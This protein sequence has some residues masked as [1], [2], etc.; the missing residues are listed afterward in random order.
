[1]PRLPLRWLVTSEKVSKS[2]QV[3]VIGTNVWASTPIWLAVRSTPEPM[4]AFD[5]WV[6]RSTL[7]AIDT[8]DEVC[9]LAWDPSVPPLIVELASDRRSASVSRLTTATSPATVM[10]GA[11][12][13]L[14]CAIEAVEFCEAMFN[15][16]TIPPLGI[17]SDEVAAPTDCPNGVEPRLAWPAAPPEPNNVFKFVTTLPTALCAEP[18]AL[19]TSALLPTVVE[20]LTTLDVVSEPE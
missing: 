4:K 19:A 9:G 12:V 5:V 15:A 16:R 1:M 3:L 17:A 2:V 10:A 18:A 13:P 7:A 6:R 11:V 20:A 8:A 14:V